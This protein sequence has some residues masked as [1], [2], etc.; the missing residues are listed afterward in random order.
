MAAPRAPWWHQGPPSMPGAIRQPCLPWPPIL[1]QGHIPGVLAGTWC[2]AAGR[3]GEHVVS[4][5]RS[6]T[7]AVGIHG[8]VPVHVHVHVDGVQGDVTRVHGAVTR[9]QL[10]RKG[11]GNLSS[12]Q[13]MTSPDLS[14][15]L[16]PPPRAVWCC[17]RTLQSPSPRA[18][19]VCAP[20]ELSIPLFT[21][22]PQ[23]TGL[24]FD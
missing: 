3:L 24:A 12:Q 21:L 19:A 23:H 9:V 18:S 8:V 2:G 22:N 11:C 7:V 16:V 10:C 6:D 20:W 13:P 15:L 4:E 1:P 5:G 17:K 14:Q